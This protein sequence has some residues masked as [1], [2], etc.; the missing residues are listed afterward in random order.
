MIHNLSGNIGGWTLRGIFSDLSDT[1]SQVTAL[2]LLSNE[3]TRHMASY[4]TEAQEFLTSVTNLVMRMSGASIPEVPEWFIP[5]HEIQREMR[6]FDC[7][8]FGEVFRGKWRGLNV[9]IKCVSVNAPMD[10]RAFHREAR[11]WH[12]A[13]HKHI[14]KFTALAIV[15]TPASLCVKRLLMEIWSTI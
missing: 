4:S 3:T 10:R 1:K 8:S 5:E 13:K 9:V 14:V 2:L 12:K 15:V 6:P 11:I 7:G